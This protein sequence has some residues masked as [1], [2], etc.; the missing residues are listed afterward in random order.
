VQF[1][2]GTYV[3]MADYVYT[4]NTVT[5]QHSII[6]ASFETGLFGDIN[7]IEITWGPACG[8]DVLSVTGDVSVPEPHVLSLLAFG[9]VGLVVRRRSLAAQREKP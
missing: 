5:T 3:G 2:G 8:N 4:R 9:L 1:Q 7:S 6:E